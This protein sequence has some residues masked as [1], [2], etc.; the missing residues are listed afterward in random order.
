L[1]YLPSGQ[2]END[3]YSGVVVIVVIVVV[4]TRDAAGK[5]QDEQGAYQN[6]LVSFERVMLLPP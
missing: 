6:A 1:T 2:L 4:G 5:G 3:R